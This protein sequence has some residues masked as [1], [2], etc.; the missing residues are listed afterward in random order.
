MKIVLLESLGISDELIE[1]YVAPLRE[2]GHVF[3]VLPA[4]PGRGEAE[5]AYEGCR[6]A[7][8]RQYAVETGGS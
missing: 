4:G 2:E 1:E 6:C 7:D 8:D 3:C 5:S